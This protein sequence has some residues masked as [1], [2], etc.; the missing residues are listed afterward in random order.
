MKRPKLSV[1]GFST[2]GVCR[3]EKGDIYPVV[4]AKASAS[5]RWSTFTD[6]LAAFVSTL[7]FLVPDGIGRGRTLIPSPISSSLPSDI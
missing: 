2:F 7:T 5:F 6:L 1:T 3:P 4:P